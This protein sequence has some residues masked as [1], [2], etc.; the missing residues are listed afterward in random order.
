M[1][2]LPRTLLRSCF[3]FLAKVQNPTGQFRIGKP[4]EHNMRVVAAL[5]ECFQPRREV[6]LASVVSNASYAD[7]KQVV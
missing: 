3:S 2:R 5:D 7:L 6:R 4:E 1:I